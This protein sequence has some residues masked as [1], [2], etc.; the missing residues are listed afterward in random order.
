MEIPGSQV[1]TFASPLRAT[2]TGID[3]VVETELTLTV[4]AK[5]A[6]GTGGPG[7]TG[8]A[9]WTIYYDSVQFPS[10]ITLDPPA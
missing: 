3:V 8:N 2:F 4:S 9:E 10:R 6:A 7:N 1:S 5:P